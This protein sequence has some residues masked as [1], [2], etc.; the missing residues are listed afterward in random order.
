MIGDGDK[1]DMMLFSGR[2]LYGGSVTAKSHWLQL[3]K[4]FP[5]RVLIS[6]QIACRILLMVIGDK[7]DDT[8]L[9]DPLWRLC[10]S[11]VTLVT[12]SPQQ[13]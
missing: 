3:F 2:I 11:I 13:G 9:Q 1:Y 8:L 10:V 12:F 5:Q 7:Y 4:F 6:F